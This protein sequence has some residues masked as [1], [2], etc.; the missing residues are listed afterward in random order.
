MTDLV[1]K[2]HGGWLERNCAGGAELREIPQRFQKCRTKKKTHTHTHTHSSCKGADNE[3][4]RRKIYVSELIFRIQIPAKLETVS[5]ALLAAV[6][7]LLGTRSV[8]STV[9]LSHIANKAIVENVG[10]PRPLK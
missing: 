3:G 7:N 10:S 8:A 2:D 9:R 1:W 5:T 6:R 4:L